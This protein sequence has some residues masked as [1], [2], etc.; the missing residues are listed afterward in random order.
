MQSINDLLRAVLVAFADHHATGVSAYH[1]WLL[2]NDPAEAAKWFLVSA[3]AITDTGQILGFG[4]YQP[5]NA[6]RAF[7]L[8]VSTIPGTV[9]EP[10]TGGAVMPLSFLALRRGRQRKRR[11]PPN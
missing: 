5:A 4:T 8:D 9:P 1:D 6:Y 2:A 10:A 7:L 11:Q 3:Q